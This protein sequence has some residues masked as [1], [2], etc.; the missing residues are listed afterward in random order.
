GQEA[1]VRLASGLRIVSAVTGD[2][3]PGGPVHLSIRP[4]RIQLAE[5]P[6]EQRNCLET[7]VADSVYQGD[8]LRVQLQN[9]VHPLV[10]KLDRRSREFPPGTKVYAAFSS[11]D[12]RIIRP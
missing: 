1:T 8:H 5:T 2:L 10:A 7:E 11:G 12:C 3:A 6:A 9:A 4:E